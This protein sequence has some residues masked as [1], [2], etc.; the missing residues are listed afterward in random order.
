MLYPIYNQGPDG[1]F[2]GLYTIRRQGVGLESLGSLLFYLDSNNFVISDSAADFN[3]GYLSTDYTTGLSVGNRDFS[4][5]GWFRFDTLGANY[6]TCISKYGTMNQEILIRANNAGFHIIAKGPSLN[7]NEAFALGVPSTSQW[8]FVGYRYNSSSKN[9]TLRVNSTDYSYGTTSG[10]NITT[11]PLKLGAF[12]NGSD[13]LDGKADS[14]GVWTKYLS[15]TE[16]TDIYN[17]G[18][19]KVFAD[20]TT[21]QLINLVSWWDL[22]ENSS[23]R[24]DSLGTYDLN[25]SGSTVDSNDGIAA[26]NASDADALKT[27]KN[28]LNESQS[29][30][31]A[32]F[33]SR[34][35]FSATGNNG[36]P[37]ISFD[38][39]DDNLAGTL[40]LPTQISMYVVLKMDNWTNGQYLLDGTSINNGA[41]LQT[42]TAP[43]IVLSAG[44][45]GARTNALN[46]GEYGIITALFAPNSGSIEINNSGALTG[47]IGSNSLSNLTLGS[48][49]DGARFSDVNFSTVLIYSG[50]HNSEIQSS[51]KNVLAST[52]NLQI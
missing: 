46:T 37:E 9:L 26:G 12:A 14:I 11:E 52:Y 38:G 28:I 50:I 15:N 27:W 3:G 2:K 24:F 48:R 19:G 33:A 34:P 22:D 20:L 41:I 29:I 30:T 8:F 18:N 51:I 35:F 25:V 17:G 10:L 6:Q 43:E 32:T 21:S 47:N 39:I 45:T 42:G 7:V 13:I 31:Q 44:V 36:V 40:S 16:V 4:T 5:F 1:F 49:G 23:T